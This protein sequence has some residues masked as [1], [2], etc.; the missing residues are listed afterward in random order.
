MEQFG[1]TWIGGN[2]VDGSFAGIIDGLVSRSTMA[3]PDHP[4]S[5]KR[6]KVEM[7]VAPSA[8]GPGRR[9]VCLSTSDI[10][11]SP[12]GPAAKVGS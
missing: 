9:S 3:L 11:A 6:F 4:L 2:K 5:V 8:I 10:L 12:I 7:T 1:A